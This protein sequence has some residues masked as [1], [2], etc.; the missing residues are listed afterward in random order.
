[1]ETTESVIDVTPNEETVENVRTD[2]PSDVKLRYTHRLRRGVTDI[3]FY[4][5]KLAMSTSIPSRVV[6]A[7]F[8]IGEK[9][10]KSREVMLKLKDRTGFYGTI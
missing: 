5:L 1:M 10:M 8:K 4:G 6:T 2:V 3:E 9:I 7:A